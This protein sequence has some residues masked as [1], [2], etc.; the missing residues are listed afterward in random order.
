MS[1]LAKDVAK[2]LERRARRRK[3]TWLGIWGALI[4]AAI[5]YLRCG[6]GWGI[7]GSGS[8]SGSGSGKGSGTG[9][10]VTASGKRCQIHLDAKG[11]TV[12]GKGMNRDTAVEVCKAAG[13][14]ELTVAG[15]AK[16]G[17]VLALQAAL[18]QAKIDTLVHDP[19]HR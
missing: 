1:E 14:A 16:H 10:A 5:V 13:S 11:I 12:D 8:G 19:S 15:D 4:A 18:T 3:V 6:S 2:E 7:G 17:D 9:A